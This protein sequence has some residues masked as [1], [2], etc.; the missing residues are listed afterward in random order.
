MLFRHS[1]PHLK[2]Q[3]TVSAGVEYLYEVSVIRVTAF[4]LFIFL[5]ICTNFI[6]TYPSA[7]IIMARTL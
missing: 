5:Y 7:F 4:L 3:G 6:N 2:A 1:C